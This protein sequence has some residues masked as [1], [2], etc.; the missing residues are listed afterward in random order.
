[1]PENEEKLIAKEGLVKPEVIGKFLAE[2]AFP[3]FMETRKRIDDKKMDPI[4]GMCSLGISFMADMVATKAQ[5]AISLMGSPR[6]LLATRIVHI[7]A[8]G[9]IAEG[10]I[11]SVKATREFISGKPET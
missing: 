2:V 10:I 4:D 7:L 9:K 8:A 3:I 5:M 11:D 1:M 6:T